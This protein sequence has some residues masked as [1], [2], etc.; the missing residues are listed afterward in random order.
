VRRGAA[1]HQRALIV[2]RLRLDLLEALLALHLDGVQLGRGVDLGGLHLGRRR[3]AV[4]WMR[5]R[6][7]S[8]YS[9]SLGFRRLVFRNW[10][11][12]FFGSWPHTGLTDSG[13]SCA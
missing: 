7:A 4:V 8:L 9:V 12:S 6:S 11:N 10:A 5:L 1:G 13:S 3:R 2:L